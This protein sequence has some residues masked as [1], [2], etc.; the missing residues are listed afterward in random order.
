MAADGSTNS[1]LIKFETRSNRVK[2]L[3]FHPKRPW[4]LSSLH[5]GAIQLWDYRMGSLIDRFEE[6]DGPVRGVDFH[7]SQ[8]LFCSGGDD[9]KIKVWNYKLRRCLFTLTDHLDY[10]RTV[11]FHK[12][13]PWILSASDD[14]TIRIWNWQARSCISVLTGHNHFVMSAQ[15]HPREDTVVSASIDQTLRLWDISH[16]RTKRSQ[17]DSFAANVTQDIFG[18]NDTRVILDGH[19]R[20][21]NYAAFHPTMPFIVSGADDRT[22]RLWRL[23]DTRTYEIEQFRGHAGNVSCVMFFKDY[24]VSNSE[25]K[26]IRVWDSKIRSA[27]HVLRR[28]NDRFW[29]LAVHPDKNLI[30]AGHDSGM[31]L[32]KLERERPA[33]QVVDNMLYWVRDRQ[34]RTYDFD[35]K[36]ENNPLALQRKPKAPPHTLSYCKEAKSV[37]FYYAQE[38]GSYELYNLAGAGG[39]ENTPLRGFYK[40]AV[41]FCRDKFAVLD[42][43]RQIILRD[44]KNDIAQVLQPVHDADAIHWAPGTNNIML[45]SNDKLYLYDIATKRVTAEASVSK[46]RYLVWSPNK[47]LVACLSE[48]AIVVLR[49]P[50]LESVCSLHR[51]RPC[52]ERML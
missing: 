15:F 9:C 20:G 46:V 45:S 44:I 13:Q 27:I 43:G 26:S 2:G 31:I 52:E 48:N 24:I 10:I 14:Q 7:I 36:V 11:Q 41:F 33:M 39:T 47:K 16:L 29:V 42:K 34:L 1:M 30:A 40:H 38:D 5:T 35:T 49:R 6:H 21:V 37:V 4:I 12:E 25:D 32:F 19:D 8:P 23:D 50:K 18:S 51:K 28:E 17:P 22:I 3:S